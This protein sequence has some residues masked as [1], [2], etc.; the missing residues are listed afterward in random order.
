MIEGGLIADYSRWFS[1]TGSKPADL[2]PG[3]KGDMPRMTG[4][5]NYVRVAKDL[6]KEW[7]AAIHADTHTGRI[8]L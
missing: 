8:R 3:N 1:M 7:R 5:A 6:E 2:Y 4:A